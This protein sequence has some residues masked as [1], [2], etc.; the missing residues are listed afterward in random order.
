MTRLRHIAEFMAAFFD[1]VVV[2][3]FAGN[4]SSEW[5]YLPNWHAPQLWTNVCGAYYPQDPCPADPTTC[6]AFFVQAAAA[7]AFSACFSCRL[8]C[9]ASRLRTLCFARWIRQ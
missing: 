7:A 8:R 4:E 2:N 1:W 5:S 3:V 6:G 9:I